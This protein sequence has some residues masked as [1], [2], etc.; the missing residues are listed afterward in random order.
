MEGVMQVSAVVP[1]SLIAGLRNPNLSMREAQRE[2]AK[3][4]LLE[5][6]AR[7]KEAKRI[8]KEQK[9]EKK[10][11]S[12]FI[13]VRDKMVENAFGLTQKEIKEY[14][15]KLKGLKGQNNISSPSLTQIMQD[16]EN[17]YKGA[18]IAAKADDK[19]IK[20]EVLSTIAKVFLGG[21]MATLS[22]TLGP[23]ICGAFS[24]GLTLLAVKKWHKRRGGNISDAVE[25]GRD[26]EEFL[27]EF[28]K[29][30]NEFTAAIEADK[31][32]IKEKM[33]T[34]KKLDFNKFLDSYLKEKMVQF[35]LNDKETEKAID[36]ALKDIK[37]E[38][39]KEGIN[40]AD[41]TALGAGA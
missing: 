17:V 7:E 20:K 28:L 26:F 3:Q 31:D 30:V 29:K 21:V 39:K 11:D 4:E 41:E 5:R 23:V 14:E 24:I 27:E 2:A 10:L 37:E 16:K 36:G 25:K 38:G 12:K 8:A 40:K 32:M 19:S 9:L 15:E 22:A 35:D 1:V 18:M 34:M 33:K 6:K 13:K